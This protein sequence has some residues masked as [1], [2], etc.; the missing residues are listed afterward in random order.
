MEYLADRPIESLEND[1][2]HR[3]SFVK[4]FTKNLLGIAKNTTFITSLNGTWGSGKTSLINLIQKEINTYIPGEKGLKYYPIIVNYSPWNT[5]D[6]DG[7]IAQFFETINEQFFSSKLRKIFNKKTVKNVFE[8]AEKIPRIGKYISDGKKLFD[9]YFSRFINNQDSIEGKKAKIIKYLNSHSYFRYIVFIDDL[10]R[11]N[12]KEIRV[13]IQLIKAVC[14]FPNIT[15]VVAYD[16]EIV[17]D[18]LKAEQAINGYQYLE[19]IV[20]VQIDIPHINYDDLKEYFINK[21]SKHAFPESEEYFNDRFET[22]CNLGFLNYFNTMRNINRLM[23]LI[24][25]KKTYIG[26]VDFVDLLIMESISLFDPEILKL[27]LN[28]KYLLCEDSAYINENINIESIN[29][30]KRDVISIGSKNDSIVS[31][32]CLL[33]PALRNKESLEYYQY[34]DSNDALFHRQIHCRNVFDFYFSGHLIRGDFRMND[35]INFLNNCELPEK[36]NVLYL[37]FDDYHYNCFLRALIAAIKEEDNRNKIKKLLPYIIENDLNSE[38]HFPFQNGEGKFYITDIIREI[39]KNETNEEILQLLL[40]IYKESNNYDILIKIIRKLACDSNYYN[41]KFDSENLK[42]L[43]FHE[44]EQLDEILFIRLK[45]LMEKDSIFLSPKLDSFIY[46]LMKKHNEYIQGWFEKLDNNKLL[47]VMDSLVYEGTTTFR[48]KSYPSYG[49]CKIQ[50]DSFVRK[51]KILKLVNK[52]LT[53]VHTFEEKRA[54]ILYLMPTKCDGQEA[55][56]YTDDEIREYESK[57]RI[58][59]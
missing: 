23:N 35:V 42:Q 49:F 3:E 53:E 34:Y 30:F 5:K 51:E 55:G 17:A 59:V 9:A 8:F 19:K 43:S 10:D 25:F 15:Y 56:L 28:N 44:I 52:Y 33:F 21:L 6:S 46:F 48:K 58:T 54:K 24:S 41:E 11:L 12:N 38:G 40:P 36:N 16:K 39:I 27:I 18:A 29:Q 7:I 14:N 45:G 4:Q 57:N 31:L 22:A 37:T 47:L 2:L 13:V 1:L 26:V 20:Q 32:L 50:I